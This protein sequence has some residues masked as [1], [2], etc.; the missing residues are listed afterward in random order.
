MLIEDRHYLC[1]PD[2]VQLCPGAKKL[3]EY[4]KTFNWP[5][6]LVTNQSGIARGLFDWAA[7]EQVTERLLFLLGS[8]APLT[9]IYANG[10]GPDEQNSTWRKPSPGML[11]AAAEDLNVDLSNSL[12]AGDRLS[13][14]QAGAEAGLPLVIH[15]LT[16]HGQNE[17]QAVENWGSQNQ[18]AGFEII[19]INSLLDFPIYKFINSYEQK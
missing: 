6:V 8:E 11:L 19:L 2:D 18:H 17:R 10:S 14:L 1:N 13:D 16:G 12:L 7:Y 9:A 15:L 5:I 3:L 4:A